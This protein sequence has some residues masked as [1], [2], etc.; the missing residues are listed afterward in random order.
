MGD[1]MA[2]KKKVLIVEDE[3][4][5]E[6]LLRSRLEFEGY[7]VISADNGKEGLLKALSEKPDLIMADLMM[8]EMDGNEMIRIIRSNSDL[9][10]IPI[11]VISARGTKEDIEKAKADGANEYFVKPFLSEKLLSTVREYLS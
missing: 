7:E 6:E 8:P 5:L 1:I 10:N 9:K 3:I 2:A 11:I 4:M